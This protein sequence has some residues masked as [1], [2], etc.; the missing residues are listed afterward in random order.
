VG[1]SQAPPMRHK[2]AKSRGVRTPMRN[3]VLWGLLTALAIALVV[4]GVADMRAT[5]RSGSPLLALGLFP[6][7]LSPIV[8]VHYLITGRVVRDL[9]N[10]RSA[11]ARWTV[12]AEQFAR[13]CEGDERIAAESFSPNFY[14]PPD[15]VPAGGVEVI[16]AEDGVLIGG[17]YFPLSATGGRRVTRVRYLAS[18]PPAIEFGTIMSGLVRTSSATMAAR[19]TA[20]TLRVPVATDATVQAADV[21]RRFEGIIARR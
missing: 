3:A 12:P 20:E 13:F 17:G 8:F 1:S 11:I 18:N 4:L 14:K 10:G 7:L 5:G 2:P 15:A 9:Q 16:F 21:V 6:A 19:R